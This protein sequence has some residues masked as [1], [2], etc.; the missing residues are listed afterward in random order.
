MKDGCECR[1]HP[2]KRLARPFYD[3]KTLIFAFPVQEMSSRTGNCRAG[4]LADFLC[5]TQMLCFK[6][7]GVAAHQPL[8]P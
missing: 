7:A 5:P 1:W 6:P 4:G 3:C 2:R 8:P